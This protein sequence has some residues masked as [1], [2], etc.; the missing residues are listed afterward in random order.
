MTQVTSHHSANA[1]TTHV[2]SHH[3]ANAASTHVTS[4]LVT[5]QRKRVDVEDSRVF[6]H[7]TES[8]VGLEEGVVLAERAHRPLAGCA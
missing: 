2:T 7:Q 5:P 6:D 8:L 4:P 3:S 1:S